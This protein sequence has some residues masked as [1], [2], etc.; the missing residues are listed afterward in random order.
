MDNNLLEFELEKAK[1]ECTRMNKGK[2]ECQ[3]RAEL[4]G[5]EL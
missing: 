4:E 3:D 1:Q 2:A 5:D